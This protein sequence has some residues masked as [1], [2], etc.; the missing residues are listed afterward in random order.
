MNRIESKDIH[1]QTLGSSHGSSFFGC[2]SISPWQDD[3]NHNEDGDIDQ[4][5]AGIL[6]YIE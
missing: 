1:I 4:R 3:V 5:N 2:W 6:G